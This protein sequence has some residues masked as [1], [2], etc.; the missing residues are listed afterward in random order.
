MSVPIVV[1]ISSLM[2]LRYVGGEFDD[3]T[4]AY[5]LFGGVFMLFALFARSIFNF[6]KRKFV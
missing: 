4:G 1:G 2:V 3:D 6:G 5:R